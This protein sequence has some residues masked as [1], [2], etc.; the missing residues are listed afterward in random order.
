VEK[1]GFNEKKI[2][3]IVYKLKKQ[4]KIMAKE[5]GIYVKA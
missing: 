2:R 4:G 3:N 1:T 5:K